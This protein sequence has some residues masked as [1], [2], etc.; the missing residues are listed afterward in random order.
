MTT[1]GALL[2][3]LRDPRIAP[4]ALAATPAWLWAADGAR[5][6]W[7]NAA[8]AATFGEDSPR[9]LGNRRFDP[10]H[11]IAREISR[12]ATAL[13]VAGTMQLARLQGLGAG[14]GRV[15]LCACSRLTSADGADGVLVVATEPCSP[16]LPFR[17]RVRRVFL[18][19]DDQTA[20]FAIEGDLLHAGV[21][22]ADWLAGYATLAD[23]G[24]GPVAAQ[25]LRVGRASGD[26]A[27]GPLTLERI[28]SGDAAVL[29]A[30]FAGLAAPLRHFTAVTPPAVSPSDAPAVAQSGA[31]SGPDLG[32]AGGALERSEDACTPA[33]P[34]E[35]MPTENYVALADT[36]ADAAP[37]A[38]AA[39]ATDVE[40]AS[41]KGAAPLMESHPEPPS[42]WAEATPSIADPADALRHPPDAV[43]MLV[44]LQSR[45]VERPH[46]LRFVWQIDAD[47]RF[48]IASD[49]FIT[50][51]GTRTAALLGQPWTRIAAELGLDADRRLE[52]AVASRDTWSGV[53]VGWPADGTAERL[54]V[55]LSGLP[56]FGPDRAFAGYR[57][58]GVCRDTD[59][60]AAIIAVR[61]ARAHEASAE[62]QRADAPIAEI[63]ADPSRANT[64]DPGVADT[65]DAAAADEVGPSPVLAE[66]RPQLT[67]VP[68]AENVVPFR[69]A[70]ATAIER[71]PVLTS[72]ERNAF[73]EI[74]KALGARVEGDT[75][76]P[77]EAAASKAPPDDGAAADETEARGATGDPVPSASDLDRQ[78]GDPPVPGERIAEERAAAQSLPR[79]SAP[80]PA[81]SG[82]D[83]PA[84]HELR[85]P[86][87]PEREILDR[88]PV[89]VLTYRGDALLYANRPFFD[90]TG[91]RDLDDF[92]AAGGLQH[93][94]PDPELQ[95]PGEPDGP[96][97]PV[98]IR[99]RS[100]DGL[101]VDGRLF[102]VGRE[103]ETALL[104]MLNKAVPD[105]RQRQAEVALRAAEADA[106][107]LASILDTATDGV[108]VTDASGQVVAANRSAEALFGFDARE[109]N[110]RAFTDLLA[111]ES[112]REALDYLDGLA[113]NGVASILNDGRE[114]I[115]RVREGGLIPLFMT[116]G[117]V[118]DE[119]PKF[120]GVFRDITQW[121]RAEEELVNARR[122]AE[123]ASSAKSDFLAK[124]SHEIRTPL[125]AIIGFSEVMM[126]QRFGPI[127]NE[128]YRGYLKDIHTSGQHLI[129]LLTDLLDLSKI[130]AGKLDL[131]FD[132]VDLN[133]VTLEAVAI[134]QPQANRER[135]IIRTSLSTSL[136]PV[137]ADVRSIRQIVLNLLSNSIKFTSAGG[138]V[139]VSTALTD[140]GEAALRVRDTGI[141]MSE[142]DI[143]TAL[144][145]FRQL[146]TSSRWSS[147]VGSG[148]GLPL[149]KA[150]AE[151][152]RASFHIKSAIDSGTLVEIIFPAT[153]V[154]AE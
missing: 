117:R 142:R 81:G 77:T 125:N 18:E 111:P 92:A 39:P 43:A 141:G 41:D 36:G 106:R 87:R 126:E 1:S 46:P 35:P 62:H 8:G 54:L 113:R 78:Q 127:E 138:Q 120:C 13:P 11:P 33:P 4:H 133:D 103:A 153:R 118:A 42:G 49:E 151:A 68:A 38:F 51:V 56:S 24:A 107:E 79:T 148:L 90:W 48:T 96:G 30:V 12:L 73:H 121:K 16:P 37:V 102:K 75:S 45:L 122:Q 40:R 74:A 98:A 134:M 70:G 152:N 86:G 55:T 85:A 100:G 64:D 52:R 135:I 146:A 71:R 95:G 65:H 61:I 72:I 136:P 129:A 28:G 115:G 10:D 143:E 5:I 139:I 128:R 84:G 108:I 14:I 23:L 137:V 60:V 123:R 3:Y 112:R 119:P 50:L 22:A 154:L 149:T 44:G 6:L 104:L 124:I 58:F 99:T 93:L 109:L 67:V 2:G 66:A 21:D 144:E 88:M 114:V 89:A 53:T 63:A 27:R 130:E 101:L 57:G 25:A 91:F 94:I 150:L 69:A 105:D 145:P 31:G 82:A 29:L 147:A 19:G 116:M 20:A 17:E 32:S 9:A 15:T 83:A 140:G 132:R 26:S 59:R 47:G 7:A 110:G 131:A 76:E 80:S 34:P 97:R